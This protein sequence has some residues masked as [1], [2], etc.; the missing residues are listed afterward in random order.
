[1]AGVELREP[2]LDLERPSSFD[3]RIISIAHFGNRLGD[4]GRRALHREPAWHCGSAGAE[5]SLAHSVD[6]VSISVPVKLMLPDRR[7]AVQGA[8]IGLA[9]AAR[10]A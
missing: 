3:V 8:K 10:G 7:V 1:M 4:F 5:V 9:F 6:P 2:P